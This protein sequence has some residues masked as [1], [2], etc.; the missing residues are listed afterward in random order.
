MSRKN[1]FT[2]ESV[3]E[4][5]PDKVCDQIS[6]TILDALLAQDPLSRVAAEVVVNTGMVVITGEIT[7]QANV[8]YVKLVRQKISEIG[9]NDADNGFSAT[10]CS[11]LVA[12]DEQ[13]PDIAQGVDSA[14]ETR[15]QSSD[16]LFDKI[17]A[18]DQG[19]MF[20]FACNETPELMP[21]PISLAHRIA[22]RLA[23]VRKNG[24][25]SY[26]RPDGK[27]QVTVIYEDARPVG[28]DTIL[29]STQHDATIGDITDEAAVQEKIKQ[30]LWTAVVE[31]VFGDITIKPDS[32]TRFLVNPT[33]KFVVG[34]PQGDAGLTGRKIIVDTYG[35]YSRHGGGAFSGK[36][37]TKVDRSAAYACRYVAKNIVAA[38]L[39]DKC[40][41]QLSYAIGV[42]RPTSIFVDTFG[43]GKVSDD[44]LLELIK[45]NFELRP[46]GIIHTLG[47]KNLPKERGGRFYQDIAAYGH[48]GRDDL[49]LPWER[50]DKAALLKAAA[51]ELKP[52]ALA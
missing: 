10:S 19:I 36:D 26:L 3:T 14:H 7:T 43:T 49:D 38:G 28:I 44:V 4:G 46:A 39:A 29:I 13:S 37:P 31:P 50:T 30:D 18:G 24:A 34:G 1:L 25:L 5:H 17:G 42:A 9:Y 12:L 6:D 40:E 47:L 22:R 51:S 20:G 15:E 45:N 8:N 35:G 2:S 48:F 32:T 11:V 41:V 21:L 27:T 52:A 33:G 16:E 23:S